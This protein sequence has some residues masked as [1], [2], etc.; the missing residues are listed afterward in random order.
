M[1]M[2]DLTER[3]ARWSEDDSPDAEPWKP[4][5]AAEAQALR[6]RQPALAPWR[7]LRVQ[8]WVGCATALLAWLV[9]GRVSVMAS[10]LYGAAAVVLPAAV[11]VG[12]LARPSLQAVA[13]LG[14][15]RLLAWEGVKLLLAVA[16]LAL[17]PRVLAPLSW[18]A[19][20]LAMVVCLKVYWLALLWRGRRD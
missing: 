5:T 9:T 20:L 10:A 19:L 11:M 7:V 14:A 1:G 3:D 2:S 13:A 4:L 8:A 12:G 17:A 15:M 18:P 6:E 16:M